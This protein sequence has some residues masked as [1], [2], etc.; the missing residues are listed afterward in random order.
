MREFKF[1][2]WD[3]DA[4]RYDITGFEHGNENEMAGVF[5]D[6]DYWRISDVA[7]I[8]QDEMHPRATVMQSTGLKDVDGVEIYE[9]DIVKL[10]F[11]IPPTSA[12]LQIIW[13]EYGWYLHSPSGGCEDFMK[14]CYPS[15]LTIIGNIY[16]NPELIEVTP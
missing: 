9:S 10:S 16:E 4:M 14:A 3:G 5:I 2:A 11:G 7:G 1:R 6:G 15:D 12:R 8:D 13:K